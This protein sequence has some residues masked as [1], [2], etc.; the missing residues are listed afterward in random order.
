M[1]RHQY[2]EVPKEDIAELVKEEEM[3]YKAYQD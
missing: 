2:D 1:G 3:D